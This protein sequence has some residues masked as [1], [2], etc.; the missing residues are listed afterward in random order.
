MERRR[1]KNTI[2]KWR[3]E[4]RQCKYFYR[5]EEKED[6]PLLPQNYTKR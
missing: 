3:L 5:K 6:N 2:G 4:R 1:K